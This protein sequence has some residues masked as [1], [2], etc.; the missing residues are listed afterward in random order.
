MPENPVAVTTIVSTDMADAVAKEYGVEL[1]RVLTGFKFIGE[2]IAMLEA[3][4]HP[5]RYILGFEESYGYLSGTHVR[6]KDAVNA[7]MLCCE[8]TAWYRAQGKTLAQAMDDLY[9]KHGCY[10]NDLASFTFEG[11]DGMAKMAAIMDTL[12]LNPPKQLAGEPVVSTVDYSG[13][14]TGL[15]RS[16]VLQFQSASGKLLVRPSGTEPK[17]KLYLSGRAETM[18]RAKQLCRRVLEET[19]AGYLR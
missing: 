5:E 18:D 1:R 17:I 15:P 12:R 4:G 19:E 14:G 13:E 16:N 2:Q 7:S 3:E 9:A 6:D 11:A 8:M 10:Y